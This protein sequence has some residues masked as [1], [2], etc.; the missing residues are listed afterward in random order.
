MSRIPTATP[1]TKVQSEPSDWDPQRATR[2]EPPTAPHQV[3]VWIARG[4]LGG[5]SMLLAHAKV[6]GAFTDDWRAVLVTALK[7]TL[8]V[9]DRGD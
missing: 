6:Q 8:Q 2:G 3:G 7:D 9:L 4:V 1:A 5:L